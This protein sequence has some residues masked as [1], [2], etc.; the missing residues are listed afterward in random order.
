MKWAKVLQKKPGNFSTWREDPVSTAAL[1]WDLNVRCGRSASQWLCPKLYFELH[2]ESLIANPAKECSALC[3]FLNQPFDEAML[4]F[5]EQREGSTSHNA[6]DPA[7][8][9]ITPG[10]KDWRTQMPAEDVEQFEAVAGS[11]LEE[12]GYPRAFPHPRRESVER[13]SRIRN[14]LA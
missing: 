14:L 3:E 5:H 1:W 12:L 10:L 8:R 13:A 9:P 7:W 4:R 11:L 6:W 2:Y